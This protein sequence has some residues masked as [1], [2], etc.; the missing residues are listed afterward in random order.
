MGSVCTKPISI[1]IVEDDLLSRILLEGLLTDSTLSVSQ[2]KCVVSLRAAMELFA[3]NKFDVVLLDL[4]LPDSKELHTLSQIISKAPQTAVIV[5]T[6]EY[7]ESL[8]LRAIAGGAQDYLV[9]ASFDH[10][11]LGKSVHYAIERKRM[12]EAGRAAF[13][14]LAKAHSEL[15][16]I[17]T[18]M[19]QSEK[20]ASIGRL[21]AGV[22]HEINTPIGFVSSNFETLGNYMGKICHLLGK[23]DELT[24]QV[25]S[26]GDAPLQRKGLALAQV[27][28]D[29]KMDFILED[30]KDLFDESLEG[31]NRISSIVQN[32]RDFSR[33]DQA[34]EFADCSLNEGIQA[35]L[36]V[37]RNELKYGVEIVTELGDIPDVPCCAGHINQV[38]LNILINAAQAI[39]S[40]TRETE[41]RIT[42]KTYATD[43]EVVCEIADN[44]PGIPADN[45]G[46]IFDP[47][48]T[49]KPVGEGVGLGLSAAYN[50]IVNE[51][52]GH[53]LVDS[54]VGQ[55][56]VFTIKLPA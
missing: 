28:R 36:T 16:E 35:T 49:T 7:G 2:I 51:H 42:I 38:F 47:F 50:T 56:T 39:G 23:H 18:Q 29:L 10:K 24:E 20:L 4:N 43:D 15:K 53:L 8:G 6:G 11:M 30:L 45:L 9:K 21:A 5:V 48:F 52:R 1:L 46:E 33:I 32:L 55:G 27:R 41:G 3:T 44:G 22:A 12:E 25:M 14:A 34:E 37:V 26:S 13:R 17:Q 31:L 19:I 40:Q 54:T